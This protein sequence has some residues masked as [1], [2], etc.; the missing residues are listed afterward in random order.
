M[1]MQLRSHAQ[2]LARASASSTTTDQQHHH[3]HGFLSLKGAS[4]TP[5]S[6]SS[7]STPY[8]NGATDAGVASGT[9]ASSN[10]V[11]PATPS[12]FPVTA[13]TVPTP[14]ESGLTITIEVY[15][16]TGNRTHHV[17]SETLK[18][19]VRISRPRLPV[20]TAGARIDEEGGD[21]ADFSGVQTPRAPLVSLIKSLSIR[22]YTESRSLYWSLVDPNI[23]KSSSHGNGS[24]ATTTAMASSAKNATSETAV[25]QE[26]RQSLQK[27]TLGQGTKQLVSNPLQKIVSPDG[28]KSTKKPAESD[29]NSKKPK[30]KSSSTA[31]E[32]HWSLDHEWA[33]AVFSE[34]SLVSNGR[35]QQQAIVDPVLLNSALANG[36]P[37]SSSTGS[38]RKSKKSRSKGAPS[39]HRLPAHSI[40]SIIDNSD[41]LVLPF[42]VMLPLDVSYDEWNRHRGA[43]RSQHRVPRPAP[44]TCKDASDASVEW[45][46]EAICDLRLS[47]LTSPYSSVP[48]TPKRTSMEALG[49]VTSVSLPGSATF[50]TN[51][52]TN[53]DHLK[54][55]QVDP[56]PDQDSD[57]SSFEEDVL[58]PVIDTRG[59]LLSKPS[60]I[61]QR[62]VYPVMNSDARLFNHDLGDEVM[63][64]IA[65]NERK[66]LRHHAGKRIDGEGDARRARWL[67]T[68]EMRSRMGGLYGTLS[69]EVSWEVG[70][71]SGALLTS[72]RM[73]LAYL[74]LVTH[75][76]F[77]L[78]RT[79]LRGSLNLFISYQQAR[80]RSFFGSSTFG[81]KN[82][83]PTIKH[84]NLAVDYYSWTKGGNGKVR[85]EVTPLRRLK[86]P[87]DLPLASC[88]SSTLARAPSNASTVSSAS[89]SASAQESDPSLSH[90][91]FTP[92]QN[93]YKLRIPFDLRNAQANFFENVAEL[94]P[95]FKTANV[96]R[97]YT[98]SVS[99][100]IDKDD[101][102]YYIG[103]VPFQLTSGVAPLKEDE[104]G[105]IDEGTEEEEEEE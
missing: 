88:L 75:K 5:N 2:D 104:L 45:V 53:P 93:R 48:T 78:P 51:G 37:N 61:V 40:P 29:K 79:N 68:I 77:Y 49:S 13:L 83:L 11:Q 86:V 8:L 55:S 15:R 59:F 16:P 90:T 94:V 24:S 6:S 4:L 95:S 52:V 72:H 46:C 47:S 80:T 36:G 41:E 50:D 100:R 39:F 97:E 58:N 89:T 82:D 64:S 43:S 96:E 38:V 63:P 18:G 9:T 20:T 76:P 87:L 66:A 17:T 91:P 69:I 3:Q 56:Q 73:S 44:P 10:M 85:K 12:P 7:G 28:K 31:E 23:V 105:G 34:I 19:I 27:A 65:E 74:Q 101:V 54:M 103:V 57:T 25:E 102:D 99:V 42:R 84:V 98:I 33:R 60:R 26:L 92:S 21:A 67:K 32:C 62:Q 22:F 1:S 81:S 35:L 30:K 70:L 14:H 71:W